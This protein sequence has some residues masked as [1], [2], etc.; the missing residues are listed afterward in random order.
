MAPITPNNIALTISVIIKS[1]FTGKAI[2]GGFM[3]LA[4]KTVIQSVAFVSIC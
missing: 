3:G 2:V 1:A 4:V